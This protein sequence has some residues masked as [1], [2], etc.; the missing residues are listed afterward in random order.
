MIPQGAP[1]GSGCMALYPCNL[2]LYSL[3]SFQVMT[4]YSSALPRFVIL[5]DNNSDASADILLLSDYQSAS[6]GAWVSSQGGERW[7][8]TE[9]NQNLTAY[10]ST[11]SELGYWKLRYGNATVVY[12][13]VALEYWAVAD[14]NGL[15]QPL[16]ADELTLNGVTYR[17]ANGASAQPDDWAMYRHDLQ[18]TGASSSAVST[19]QLAWRFFTGNS[20]ASPSLADRLRASPTV[21]DG[22]LYMGSN[23]SR[24]YALNAS[25]GSQI[26][27]VNVGV[28][29]DSSAA[30]ANGVVYVGL[31]WDGHHG[32]VDAFNA[33]NGALIWQYVT[34]GG[35]ESSPAVV[36]GV[37][38][39]GTVAGYV[40]ALNASSGAQMWSYR[41]G[42][43]VFS[44]PNFVDGVLYVGSLDGCVYALNA[45][46]GD[47]IWASYFGSQVY[48]SPVVVD[49]V[50]YVCT[51]TGNVYALSAVD[52]SVI[53][54][55]YVGSGN[56]HTDSS[57]AVAH[58][59]VYVGARN[60]FYAFNATSGQQLWFFNSPYTAR[61]YT[62]YFYSSPTVAGDVVYCGYEDSRLFALNA[63]NG[64][65]VWSYLTGGFLF[66]SP[67]IVDGVVYIGSYD[68]YIYALG[69]TGAAHLQTIIPESTPS[70]SATPAP[71]ST[72]SQSNSPTATPTPAAVSEPAQNEPQTIEQTQPDLI[73]QSQP[74]QPQATV[75]PSNPVW[76]NWYILAGIVAAALAALISLLIVFK[77]S[78][79]QKNL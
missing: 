74:L 52:G 55:A 19:G 43:Q 24:F 37:V 44:S 40:H 49:G 46:N 8:W 22:V 25:S 53:W 31:L 56:D 57:P 61:H 20:P 75:A 71:S 14:A 9:A 18:R 21:A 29:I 10:G 11:W 70:S 59:I 77:P 67:V 3:L 36:D 4:S 7:G 69:Y 15:G 27:A 79:A 26:W 38:Y 54:Q 33:T 78:A 68:G 72:A 48:S 28:N 60:G 34:S 6:N 73:S 17:I 1:Q 12:V 30:V 2:T 62:G 35:V 47:C 51:D 50:I 76:I 13:G 66:S 64:S 65:I 42:G 16:Y 41:T 63:Y 58:G 5:L 45:A 32:Y 39:V 23:S